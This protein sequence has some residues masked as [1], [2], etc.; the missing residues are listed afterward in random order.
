MSREDFDIPEVF[1][2][3]MEEAGWRGEG[4][5]G[6]GDGDNGGGGPHRPQGSPVKFNRS[7][8]IIG[9]LFI[10]LLSFNWVVNVYTDWLWFTELSYDEVWLKQWAVRLTV[11]VVAIVIAAAVLLGNWLIARRLAIRNTS[12]FH[13]QFLTPSGVG[14]LIAGVAIFLA[15][16]FASGAASQWEELLLFLNRIPFAI[17]DPIFNRDVGFYIFELPVYEFLQGWL[18]SLTFL[19]LLGILPIY[20][21]NQ[22]PD[23]QRGR[24][25]P[26]ESVDLRRHVA[27]LAGLFLALWSIGYLFDIFGLLYSPRG[28]V[29][30]ASYTDMN[31]SLWALR[32]QFLFMAL[33]S[34][35]VFYNIFR[36]SF[37]PVLIT[38]GL[39]LAATFLLGGL[40]PGLLQRYA[41]EPNEM[42]R[43]RPFIDHNINFTRQAFDL[44]SIEVRPWDSVTDLSEQDLELNEDV[45][46]N[47]RLWDYRPLQRTYE[48]LQALRPYYQF[49]LIDIDRYEIDGEVR[50]VMLA[51]RELNKANLPAPS[52]VNRNLEFTHGYGIVMNPVDSITSDGQPE[53]F[54]QDLPPQSNID[55]E[56]ERPEIY[57]GELTT[58]AVFVSSGREEFSYPSGSEN[59][60]TSYEG[61]GG[62]PLDS[63]LKRVA[64]A[65][66]LGD[67]NVLLSDE[68]DSGTRVQFHRSI[69]DRVRQIAPFLAMDSDPYIV[70]L[71]DRL[72]WIQDTYTISDN[73]PYSTPAPSGVN[74][75][76]NAVK[77]VVNAYDGQ[78]DFYVADD[79]DPIIQAYDKALPGLF[80]PFSE[81]PPELISHIRYP[82]DLFDIQGEQFLAYHM[83]DNRVFYN[84]EDLWAIPMEIFDGN[85]QTMEPY[86][87]YLRLREEVDPE[88]LLIQPF[89][90]A[91]KQNM[92]AWMAAR[93]D[94]E[95][96][97]ELIVYELPKQELVFGPL[98]VEG[99][100]D[101]EPEISQQFSLWDQRGS[102]VIRGNL[103][104]I[105]LSDSFVFVEPIY[106]LSDTSALPEL[107]RVIVAT[108]TR[109]A[110]R[111]TLGEAL[112]ALLVA[113]RLEDEALA[114]QADREAAAEIEDE[115][116]VPTPSAPLPIDATIEELVRSANTHFEAAEDAQKDGDWATYGQELQAL[117]SD[118]QRLMELAGNEP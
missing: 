108:D 69:Q 38:G 112:L 7:I 8:W 75:I 63:F 36:F 31:A 71:D 3:A 106:L 68:I 50:Q 72:V 98:Q 59:V 4:N 42:E 1:R 20:A 40:Y 76:R 93:N 62:V 35:A 86:Y 16:T 74:Y 100:I 11:F 33:T 56:V 99:R 47:V 87:V 39:W 41:V 97:G 9:L 95:H 113:D 117:N 110:M 105:P 25:R 21:I 104:V 23:I 2:R 15:F 89:T 27:L 43:E 18:L 90:P 67:A 24:W 53:F 94:P 12:P 81:F 107:K 13:P 57:Y 44:D 96:Y 115:A 103:L 65:I 52:W 48:Q 84:K 34:L 102:R 45:V 58:D 82:Q 66:R 79:D 14:W 17:D 22:L 114:E 80:Q 30:G 78:V 46:R 91:G 54:I 85:E 111:E 28:V 92:I 88:Y 60:Y 83:T 26:Q 70:A 73:Y 118:L 51:G 77:V 32:A 61:D 116:A 109:I 19:A 37:R 101:Q 29:F 10:L 64:F 49:S 5:D 6:E 55:L